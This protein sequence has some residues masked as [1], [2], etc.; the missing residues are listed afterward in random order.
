MMP[1]LFVPILQLRH[2]CFHCDTSVSQ[3]PFEEVQEWH[4]VVAFV[5]KMH[6]EGLD[7]I[8]WLEHYQQPCHFLDP[9]LDPLLGAHWTQSPY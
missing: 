4:M 2:E 3:L 1:E 5:V 6:L 9:L 7:E 8:K